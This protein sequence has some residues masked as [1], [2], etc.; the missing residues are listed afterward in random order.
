MTTSPLTA[1]E[2]L[3]I[4]ADIKPADG[5]F[6]CGPSKVR[7]EQLQSL[8]TAGAEGDREARQPGAP[9]GQVRPLV[10]EVGAPG[11]VLGHRSGFACYG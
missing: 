1:P 9:P 3:N 7:P 11:R 8:A 5:R 4:P 2:T 6:G 10:G